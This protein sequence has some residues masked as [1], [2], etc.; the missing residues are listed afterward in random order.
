[1]AFFLNK[2]LVIIDS[3]QFMNCSLENLAK[4]LTDNDFKYLSEEF[5]SKNIELLKQKM[6]ILMSPWTVFK[7]LMK[8]NFSI[9][10]VFTDQ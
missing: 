10:N 3:M 2:N 6:P 8:K 5:G 7:D 9:K 4:N 1:M